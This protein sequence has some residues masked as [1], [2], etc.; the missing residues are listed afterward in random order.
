MSTPAEA[1]RNLWAA[2][3]E[4]YARDVIANRRG[5][6][7]DLRGDRAQLTRLCEPL[8]LDPEWVAGGL[9]ERLTTREA[10]A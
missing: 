1:A 6:R 7:K 8:E 5:A 3:L 4:L 9:L 2:A 10:A